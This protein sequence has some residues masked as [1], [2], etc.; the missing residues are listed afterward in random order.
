MQLAFSQPPYS[1]VSVALGVLASVIYSA[2]FATFAIPDTV[3]RP[4]SQI[5]GPWV[6][7][8][9]LPVRQPQA[10]YRTRPWTS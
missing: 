1:V 9:R 3:Y 6:G 2:A 7:E 8:T 4:L 10:T 5:L